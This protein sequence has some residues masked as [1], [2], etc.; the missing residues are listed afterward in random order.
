MKKAPGITL[1]LALAGT[2]L[3]AGGGKEEAQGI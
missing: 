2:M 1:M 3:F